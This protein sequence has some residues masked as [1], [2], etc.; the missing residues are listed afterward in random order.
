MISFTSAINSTK[1]PNQLAD[2]DPRLLEERAFGLILSDLKKAVCTLRDQRAPWRTLS[3][4]LDVMSLYI[5]SFS[6]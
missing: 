6:N 1:A 5:K 4:L 3:K 2:D